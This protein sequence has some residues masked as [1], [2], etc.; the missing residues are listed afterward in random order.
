[1]RNANNHLDA[2]PTAKITFVTHRKG[3]DFLLKGAANKNGN[4]YNINVEKLMA[5][6]VSFDVRNSTMVACI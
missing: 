6:G 1:M 3:F 4:S 5:R 2:D